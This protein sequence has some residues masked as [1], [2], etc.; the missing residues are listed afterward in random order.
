MG[1]I[2]RFTRDAKGRIVNASYSD[3]W[4]DEG[5]AKFF[6]THPEQKSNLILVAASQAVNHVQ[7]DSWKD[8]D[9]IQSIVWNE[10]IANSLILA[11][12]NADG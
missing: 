2:L 7:K 3:C 9:E 8:E 1:E 5:L 4:D 6:S 10:Q 12:R 11:D